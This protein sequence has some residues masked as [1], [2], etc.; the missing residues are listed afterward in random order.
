MGTTAV[1]VLESAWDGRGL[2]AGEGWTDL[3]IKPPHHFR[4]VD[5]L[6]TNFHRPRSSLLMLAAAF[7]GR[8][9]LLDAYVEA[10]RKDY[11]FHSYGDAMFIA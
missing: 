3:V 7:A 11:R 4:A 10:V 8:D 5:A 6:I 1:R 2:R 9:R